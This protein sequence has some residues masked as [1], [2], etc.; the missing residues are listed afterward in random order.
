MKFAYRLNK[1]PELSLGLFTLPVLQKGEPK[2]RATLVGHVIA[3][4]SPATRVT[5][6]SMQM[7]ANW[8][9]ERSSVENGKTVGHDEY[10]GTIAVHS[11][12]VLPEHQGKQVGTTLMK[13][14]IQRIKEASIAER[15]VLIAHDNM[16]PYYEGFGFENRG[17][18]QCQYGGGSWFD[19]VR[20]CLIYLFPS[21]RMS[22]SKYADRHS[23]WSSTS[24]RLISRY[25]LVIWLLSVAFL[26]LFPFFF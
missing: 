13:S 15:I 5:D 20:F 12:A 9:N 16:V 6:L 24:E 26:L 11:L 22:S 8:R 3:T 10:S 25:R 7:P 17:P 1:C 21:S 14:Y 19:M 23:H 18:S 4:R 2:P